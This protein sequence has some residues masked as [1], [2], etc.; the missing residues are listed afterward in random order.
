LLAL[1]IPL[2]NLKRNEIMNRVFD[3][4]EIWVTVKSGAYIKEAIHWAREMAINHALP[5]VF[6]FS[7][8]EIM[9]TKD[10]DAEEVE[11]LYYKTSTINHNLR[12]GPCDGVHL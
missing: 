8:R 5:V 2:A 3:N 10:S 6:E 12:I 11:R 7:G 1:K 9:V 4:P